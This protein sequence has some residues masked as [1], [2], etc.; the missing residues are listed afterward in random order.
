MKNIIY[1]IEKSQIKNL[2]IFRSGDSIE[3]KIWVVEGNKKRLQ[4]FEGLVIAVKKRGLNS[5][6]TVRKNSGSENVERVFQTH[7]PII[8]NIFVKRY[9]Y[10]RKS[11]LYYLRKKIGKAARIKERILKNC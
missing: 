9:G 11:K 6:F 4:S 5:S 10:V 1:Q 7:S 8:S 2:P 3:V